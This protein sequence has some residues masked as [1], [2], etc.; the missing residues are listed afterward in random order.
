MINPYNQNSINLVQH[1]AMQIIPKKYKN[2][3][4]E[5]KIIKWNPGIEMLKMTCHVCVHIIFWSV[6][7]I[8]HLVLQKHYYQRIAMILDVGMKHLWINIKVQTICLQ[9]WQFG[10]V[11]L[12][13]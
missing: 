8:S 11:W 4:K 1:P 5:C 9:P 13:L 3:Y 2:S 10:L 6:M 12:G 7:L